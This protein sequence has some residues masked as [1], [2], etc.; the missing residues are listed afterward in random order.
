MRFYN[1]ELNGYRMRDLLV[2]WT[3]RYP[4]SWIPLAV[5]EAIY[6]GRLKAIS[7]EQILNSWM[8][9]GSVVQ[10]FNYEFLHLIQ[11]EVEEEVGDVGEYNNM[12]LVGEEGLTMVEQCDLSHCFRKLRGFVMGRG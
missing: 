11:P 10:S 6:Q 12:A 5:A 1:F 7:V 8:R 3:R 4:Q 2:K 9:R